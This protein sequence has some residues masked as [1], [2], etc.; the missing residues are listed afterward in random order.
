MS[1]STLLLQQHALV[2]YSATIQKLRQIKYE[3]PLQQLLELSAGP[4]DSSE[5]PEENSLS[6]TITENCSLPSKG[7]S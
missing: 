7:E 5:P 4:E 3:E 6:R 2:N 1:C